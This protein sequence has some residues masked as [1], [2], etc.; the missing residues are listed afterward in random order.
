MLKKIIPVIIWAVLLCIL[1]IFCLFLSVWMEISLVYAIVLWFFFIFSVCLVSLLRK[2][3]SALQKQDYFQKLFSRHVFSRTERILYTHWRSGVRRL[4]KAKRINKVYPWFFIT[5]AGNSHSTLLSGSEMMP[6]SGCRENRE[7][8]PAR[9]LR[10]WFFQPLSFLELPGLFSESG[11]VKKVWKRTASW[12][13]AAPPPAGVVVCI[14]VT[15]LLNL[16]D[17]PPVIRGR[18]IR[19]CLE[20]LLNKTRRRLPVYVLV[21]E[22]ENIPGFSRWI[23]ALSPEQQHQPLGYFWL[24][25]PA[26]DSRDPSFLSPLFDAMREG[27]N[28]VRISMFSGAKPDADT[29]FLLDMPEQMQSLQPVLHQYIASICGDDVSSDSTVPA[30]GG[31]WFTATEPVSN[32]SNERKSYFTGE[33][34]SRTLP[35]ISSNSKILYTCPVRGF[36]SRWGTLFIASIVTFLLLISATMTFHVV[37]TDKS[38]DVISS[39]SQLESIDAALQHPVRYL[40][41]ISVLYSR[42][43]EIEDRILS[44]SVIH[45]QDDREV[46]SRYHQDFKLAVPEKQREL[47][48]ELARAVVAKE[49]LLNGNALASSSGK[50][51]ISP[52][53]TMMTSDISLTPRQ[54]LLLQRALLLR[55]GGEQQISRLRRLL[56]ELVSDDPQWRWLLASTQQISPVR[57]GSF[58]PGSGDKVSIDGIWTAEG[59]QQ[60]YRWLK[61]IHYAAGKKIDLPALAR[62]EQRLPALRQSAWIKFIIQ[63]N[64]LPVSDLS[65]QQWSDILLNIAQGNSPATG[66]ARMVNQQLADI[67]HADASPWLLQLRKLVELQ[68]NSVSGTLVRQFSQRKQELDFVFGEWLKKGK[69]AQVITDAGLQAQSWTDWQSSLHSAVSDALNSPSDTPLLTSGLFAPVQGNENNPLPALSKRFTAL[70]KNLIFVTPDAG[71]DAVWTLYGQDKK[72]II[73]HA[74]QQSG[75]WLQHQWQSTVLWPLEQNARR[76]D[77]PA[78]Q[79]LAHQYISSFMRDSAKHVLA[80]GKNGAEAGKFEGQHI[81]LSQSFISL[82]NA[83]LN[84]DD[85]LPMPERDKTRKDDKLALL[86]AQQKSLEDKQKQLESTPRELSL[87]SL[88]ATVPGGAG[89]MPVGTKL[90]LFCDDQRWVLKSMNFDEQALFR[91]RPGHCGRVAQLIQFPGFSLEY[92]Y[93]GESAWPDFLNDIAEGQHTYQAEDFSDQ[94]ALLRAQGIKQIMVRYQPA[95]QADVQ[96]TWRQWQALE[97]AL[98]ENNSAQQ[99]S[100]IQSGDGRFSEPQKHLLSRLPAKIA[101]CP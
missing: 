75:C 17:E 53:L 36:L 87:H 5:A 57:S 23:S 24:T 33:L 54:S 22:C 49:S 37:D 65:E 30:L 63:L 8:T 62:F 79:A 12:F 90:T 21:T 1:F 31:I 71:V 85:L 13:H 6:A 68:T 101:S 55:N 50:S 96:E 83:E 80:I 29:L 48:L 47:I 16:R 46:I 100:L 3:L 92:N 11:C 27:L 52:A 51:P 32:T 98:D 2:S 20:P 44:Y 97:H 93:T 99:A 35:F 25:P 26:I 56:G 70:R 58:F 72:L 10:W 15:E 95:S 89:L 41:F 59:T 39:L 88:P 61:E 74:M 69:G 64:R 94:A 9:T 81:K 34:F 77:Y 40:P 19:A 91:W 43:A 67:S 28:N 4:K 60:I 18:R 66:L 14:S 84:P 38:S 76:I 45:Y 73:A 42:Q 7:I 86:R 82:I 78:Q